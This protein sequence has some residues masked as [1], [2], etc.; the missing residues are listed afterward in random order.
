MRQGGELR[1]P[2]ARLKT[3]GGC[4]PPR[5]FHRWR[6]RDTEDYA[7]PRP[8]TSVAKWG[9]KLRVGIE[10]E[11]L[12]PRRKAVENHAEKG[13]RREGRFLHPRGSRAEGAETL[14]VLR[15]VAFAKSGK[16][17]RERLWRRKRCLAFTEFARRGSGDIGEAS[18]RIF[19]AGL[20]KLPVPRTSVAR[21]YR[22]G[23]LNTRNK[24]RRVWV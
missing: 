13:F 19:R 1:S 3:P 15:W 22:P 24:S 17:R 20:L 4:F 9:R 14:V 7:E 2:W 18:Q 5:P 6:R 16:F 8:R 12:P 10:G 21:L 11:A 23:G